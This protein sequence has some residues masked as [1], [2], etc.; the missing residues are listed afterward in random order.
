[1]I[2]CI[3]VPRRSYSV[4]RE[5]P[6]QERE[7]KEKNRKGMVKNERTENSWK[8]QGEREET[9]KS[10]QKVVGAREGPPGEDP[11]R[12]APRPNPRIALTRPLTLIQ[13]KLF[14]LLV[15]LIY[16]MYCTSLC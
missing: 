13:L 16:Y 4:L 15:S 7:E 5:R 11:R 14:Q 8:T 2:G 12:I 9:R 6:Q 1:M 10:R 3:L